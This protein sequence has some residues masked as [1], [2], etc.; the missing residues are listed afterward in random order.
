M[1]QRKIRR[2]GLGVIALLI[3]MLFGLT[4]IEGSR[5]RAWTPSSSTLE[6][7]PLQP[8]VEDK[9]NPKIAYM[10]EEIKGYANAGNKVYQ[11]FVKN[12]TS[13]RNNKC[14]TIKVHYV[15]SG[16]VAWTTRFAQDAAKNGECSINY[17][18]GHGI[19]D[20]KKPSDIDPEGEQDV[21]KA[22]GDKI[23]KGDKGPL[24]GIYACWARYYNGAINKDNRVVEPFDVPGV[25]KH[26]EVADHFNKNF[27][28]IQKMIEDLCKKCEGKVELHLYFGSW[29]VKSDSEYEYEQKNGNK[30]YFKDW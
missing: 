14:L 15:R 7:H 2:L 6:A 17:F 8:Q 28:K 5:P 11:E 26:D 19:A 21:K 30:N 24:F 10:D 25:S 22:L 12:L 16:G 23:G 4:P 1:N 9:P 27:T 3:A 29:E 20:P 18:F 13:L